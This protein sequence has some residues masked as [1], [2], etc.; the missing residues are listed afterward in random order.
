MST[1]QERPPIPDGEPDKWTDAEKAELFE[2][3]ADLDISDAANEYW[4][5][6]A[7]VHRRRAEQ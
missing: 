6:M 2:F 4:A 1:T 7:E 3:V 5:T